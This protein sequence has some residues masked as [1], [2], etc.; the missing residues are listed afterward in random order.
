MSPSLRCSLW[1]RCSINSGVNELN[2]AKPQGG[3]RQPLEGSAREVSSRV[4]LLLCF[5]ELEEGI[6]W[7]RGYEFL[8]K[9]LQG[10]VRGAEEGRRHEDKLIVDRAIIAAFVEEVFA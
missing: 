3:L 7:S 1:M 10:I 2:G 9:E 6:D 4:S 8:D 5:P